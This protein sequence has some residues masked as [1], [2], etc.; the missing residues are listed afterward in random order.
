MLLWMVS[1]RIDPGFTVWEELFWALILGEKDQ[2]QELSNII[3]G[4]EEKCLSMSCSIYVSF[5]RFLKIFTML[6]I[7]NL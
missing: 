5:P 3:C 1:T 6:N 4:A 7:Q 2:S